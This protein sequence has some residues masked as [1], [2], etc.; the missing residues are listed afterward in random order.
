MADK[1]ARVIREHEGHKINDVVTLS[2]TELKSA[3]NDGWVDDDPEAV[4]YA[5]KLNKAKAAEAEE[6]PAE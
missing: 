4:K 5:E 6:Q 3:K 2:E 1:K